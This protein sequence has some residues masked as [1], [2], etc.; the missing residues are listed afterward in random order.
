M[1]ALLLACALLQASAQ[2]SFDAASIKESTSLETGG[3]MRMMPDGGVRAANLAAR[4][5]ITISYELQGYQIANAPAW[6]SDT[7]YNI[8]AKPAAQV[9]RDQTYKMLQALL[10]ERFRFAFHRE[11][12]E[13]EGFA[14]VRASRDRLGPQLRVSEADCQAK[15][16]ET[17][18]CREGR[19]GTDQFTL[20]GSPIATVAQVLIGKLAGPVSDG[21]GLAGRY[22]IEM[23][24]TNDVASVDDRTSIF[25]ALQ[26]QL[27]LR[28]ER[29]RT[30]T[31]VLVV[32]RL[33]RPTP[34]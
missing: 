22:D 24:W 13:V 10:T 30:K 23:Q 6:A 4:A 20:I 31:E 19:I 5:L 18:R 34:D 16:L 12:R 1:K 25:T 7:R 15:F 8:E 14:L 28:L 9:P 29:R 11:V 17:P 33:E 2:L 32:D 27:G 21:T 26:E 3:S